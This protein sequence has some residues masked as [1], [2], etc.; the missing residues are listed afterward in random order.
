MGYKGEHIHILA[1]LPQYSAYWRGVITGIGKYCRQNSNLR[2]R[3]PTSEWEIIGDSESIDGVITVIGLPG[4]SHSATRKDKPVVNVSSIVANV[5]FPTI[6]LDNKHI[7]RLAAE[8]LLE[9]GYQF[10][11]CH[12]ESRV[13][14]SVMRMAGFIERLKEARKSCSVFDT[15]PANGVVLSS[16]EVHTKTLEW[17]NQLPK[18]VGLFT[19]NDGR[20]TVLLDFCRDAGLNVPNQVGVIGVDNDQVICLASTPAL[21]SVDVSPEIIGYRA[22]ALLM[23]LIAGQSPPEEPLLVKPKGVIERQSTC[24]I[25]MDDDVLSIAMAFIRDHSEDRIDVSDLLEIVPV[26]RRSLERRFREQLGRS[27]L[28]EIRKS[29]ILRAKNLLVDSDLT[30]TA[31]SAACGYQSFRNFATAFKRDVGLTP[32]AFRKS[33]RLQ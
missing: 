9:Q 28:D 13:H 18:P 7:G 12:I 10:F 31:I 33:M 26:S 1:D 11:A 21:S 14:F 5:S 19:H 3:L 29:K 16:S 22:A 8:H 25:L 6:T 32:S 17:L 23:D 4:S 20:A 30:L 15:A 24:P 2:L 27:P